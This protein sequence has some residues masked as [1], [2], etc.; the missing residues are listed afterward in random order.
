MQR[1]VKNTT[2]IEKKDDNIS[3]FWQ[4]RKI[5]KPLIIL[6]LSANIFEK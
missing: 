3:Q 1:S 4:T 2:T 5:L 6:N